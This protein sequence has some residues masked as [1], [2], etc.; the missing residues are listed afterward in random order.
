MILWGSAVQAKGFDFWPYG[1]YRRR[2]PSTTR[3]KQPVSGPLSPAWTL[4]Q[5]FAAMIFKGFDVGPMRIAD[6]GPHEKLATAVLI[7]AMAVLQP[8]HERDSTKMLVRI[9]FEQRVSIT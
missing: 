1:G 2:K 4:K 6:D 8:I 3:P 9:D 7:A 5:V